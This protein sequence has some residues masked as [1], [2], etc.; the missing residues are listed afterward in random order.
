MSLKPAQKRYLRGL[1][2]SLKP[3]ILVGNKGVTP[4]LV[5]EFSSALDHHEL[6]KVRLAGDDRAERAAQIVAL[7]E[8]A[9]A[10]L[11][12]S[13]GKVATYFRRNDETPRI[14]LPN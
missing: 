6:I 7:G 10:E 12:Q 4:A 9:S 13:V 8:A 11:V 5:A 3:L 2:H 14:A 1:A